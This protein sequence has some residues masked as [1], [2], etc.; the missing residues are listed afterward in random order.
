MKYFNHGTLGDIKTRAMSS[1]FC[2]RKK[3]LL[4][5]RFSFC[6]SYDISSHKKMDMTATRNKAPHFLHYISEN[7]CYVNM[8]S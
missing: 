8:N 3:V 5:M 7:K 2:L 6:N 1:L 4:K